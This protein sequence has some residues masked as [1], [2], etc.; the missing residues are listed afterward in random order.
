MSNKRSPIEDAVNQLEDLIDTIKAM[1]YE[2]DEAYVNMSYG[3]R[4]SEKGKTS[5]TLVNLYDDAIGAMCKAKKALEA[6]SNC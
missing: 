4:N 3:E 6:A 5:V 2:E 1:A